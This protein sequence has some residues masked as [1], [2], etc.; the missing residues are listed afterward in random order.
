MAAAELSIIVPCYNE[1]KNIPLI[2]DQFRQAIGTRTNVELIAVDNGSRDATS[3]MLDQE[4]ARPGYS[5]VRKAA[6]KDNQGYGFGILAGL[7]EARGRVLAWT[8]A[9]LQTDAADVLRA[10]ERYQEASEGGGKKVV[11]KGHRRNRGGLEKWFSLGMQL[12]SSAALGQWLTE[13]NAQ[14]KLFPREFYE[15]MKNPPHD[16]S[17]DLYLLCLAR[18][19]GYQVVSIP[20]YFKPRRY[21]EAKG[22]GGSSLAVKWKLVRRTAAY[23]FRLRKEMRKPC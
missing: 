2:L 12:L 8:H 13:V 7:R 21:G 10:Y 19:K 20:V 4:M 16:F 17:L 11:V 9:D 3:R 6:V 15:Q 23:I 5:F 22:G 14:P 18:Q 1:E